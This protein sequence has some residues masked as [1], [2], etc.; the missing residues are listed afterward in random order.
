MAMYT[1][2]YLK[3][4]TNKTYCRAHVTLPNVIWQSGQDGVWGRM[5]T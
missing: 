1:L 3:W 2:V 4:I 5:D